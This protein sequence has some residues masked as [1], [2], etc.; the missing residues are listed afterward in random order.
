MGKLAEKLENGHSPKPKFYPIFGAFF[1][2][3]GKFFHIFS[4]RPKPIFFLFFSYF[5]LE[6]RHGVCTRRTESQPKHSK[7]KGKLTSRVF[8]VFRSARGG[9]R[10]AIMLPRPSLPPQA[11]CFHPPPPPPEKKINTENTESAKCTFRVSVLGG[12]ASLLLPCPPPQKKENTESAE[13]RTFRDF[14]SAVLSTSESALTFFCLFSS[15]FR[16]AVFLACLCVFA[17]FSNDFK[18]S[19]ERKILFLPKEGLEGRGGL[20]FW[21]ILQMGSI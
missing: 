7:T 12:G 17:L 15:L 13:F 18:A 14:F 21:S 9:G 16:F 5:R 10:R 3:F 11:Y 20:Q 6:A 8:R 2:F 4:E 19:A 1:L